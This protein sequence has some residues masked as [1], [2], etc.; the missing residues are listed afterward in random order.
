MCLSFH[1]KYNNDTVKKEKIDYQL[2]YNG[3]TQAVGPLI[4]IDGEGVHLLDP[5]LKLVLRAGRHRVHVIV[6]PV[7]VLDKKKKS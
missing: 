1:N 7:I 3:Q 4:E 5:L 2:T 6:A